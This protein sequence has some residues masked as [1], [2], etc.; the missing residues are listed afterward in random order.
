[1]CGRYTLT[2]D[3]KFIQQR[4]QVGISEYDNIPRYNI[5]PS[6]KILAVTQNGIR[7]IGYMHW[8][9]IPFWATKK[10]I[11]YNMINARAESIDTSKTFGRAFRKS[12]CLLIA[13]G[14]YEWR[15][16][17]ST[18][19]PY[20]ITLKNLEPF[21]FAGIYEINEKIER[22]TILSCSIITCPSNELIGKIHNRMPVILRQE[23]ERLWLNNEI[24]QSNVLS[25]ML[26]P[27]PSDSME[28][29]PVSTFVN[30]TKNDTPECIMRN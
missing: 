9:F 20:R 8:G 11:G 21:A 25:N 16:T 24:Y 17:N 30:S 19:I 13:D 3:I 1:M 18:K 29:Y 7:N 6:Q 15:R 14:F 10:S 4:F 26:K 27:F 28:A 22:G 12:R 2:S 5:A 23:S